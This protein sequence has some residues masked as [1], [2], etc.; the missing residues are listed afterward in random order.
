MTV[1]EIAEKLIPIMAKKE[2]RTATGAVIWNYVEADYYID[3]ENPEQAL[4]EEAVDLIIE[5]ATTVIH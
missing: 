5:A 3:F 4:F 1:Y 2:N